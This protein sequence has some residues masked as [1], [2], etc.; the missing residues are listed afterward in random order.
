MKIKE[1]EIV[2]DMDGT[3]ADLYG[4]NNWL[5]M[6]RAE[7]PLPYQIAK[8]MYNMRNL[9]EILDALKTQ[10]WTITITTWL[11]MNSSNEYKKAVRKAKREWLEKWGFPYD[12]IHIVQ[13]GT[14]K[15]RVTKAVRHIL[16]D[17]SE[18]VRN[19]WNGETVN[20]N[21][22]IIPSLISFLAE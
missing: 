4:V 21:E 11:S 20:A 8:P 7:N 9:A 14:P 6:L 22:N 19:A 13:Y 3:I 1:K 10:G 15:H 5:E 2:F 12:E 18:T 17:D 16:V